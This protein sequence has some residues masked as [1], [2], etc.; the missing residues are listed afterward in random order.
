[1]LQEFI[2]AWAETGA[3]ATL[4]LTSGAIVARALTAP[5]RSRNLRLSIAEKHLMLASAENEELKRAQDSSNAIFASVVAERDLAAMH[6][7]QAFF[8]LETERQTASSALT[9]LNRATQNHDDA[10]RERAKAQE[11]VRVALL[12]RD[13][14]R[15]Q[16]DQIKRQ[17]E[18]ERFHF[19]TLP[20]EV[21]V[22]PPA[23]PFDPTKMGKFVALLKDMR[24]GNVLVEESSDR[25]VSLTSLGEQILGVPTKGNQVADV[26]LA[27]RT[28][29]VPGRPVG[30]PAAFTWE[31][32]RQEVA[33]TVYSQPY[34]DPTDPHRW[35][36][37][38]P[39]GGSDGQ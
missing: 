38:P 31:K 22:L 1:M 35:L 21:P 29:Q 7:K 4:A 10:I 36:A 27:F 14:A 8:D 20:P 12:E 30:F 18:A 23:A 2:V 16:C 15:R 28:Q 19:S 33:M 37:P 3:F 32:V 17:F 26:R 34:F 9:S 13:D 25:V 5:G 11:R 39:P 6:L 24:T